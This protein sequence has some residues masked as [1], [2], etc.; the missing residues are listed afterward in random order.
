MYIV[1]TSLV[2]PRSGL[3][4][5]EHSVPC[6]PDVGLNT[7][8]MAQAIAPNTFKR[9]VACRSDAMGFLTTRLRG[10]TQRSS[11]S[12]PDSKPA[13]ETGGLEATSGTTEAEQR[14]AALAAAI[15]LLTDREAGSGK[16]ASLIAASSE[17]QVALDAL[18]QTHVPVT[19]TEAMVRFRLTMSSG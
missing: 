10:L 2:R 11:G 5:I 7:P 17:D 18:A 8:A 6:M 3:C 9:A 15:G 13:S 16:G 4:N 19:A 1:M 12:R 14:T